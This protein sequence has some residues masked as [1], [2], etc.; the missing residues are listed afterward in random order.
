MVALLIGLTAAL[1]FLALGVGMFV[2]GHQTCAPA[3]LVE[4]DVHGGVRGILP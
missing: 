4:N 2:L 3:L 1:G